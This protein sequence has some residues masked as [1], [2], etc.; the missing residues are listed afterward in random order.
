MK[1]LFIV[2]IILL[3]FSC[4]TTYEIVTRTKTKN[5]QKETYFYELMGKEQINM[6]FYDQKIEIGKKIKFNKDSTIKVLK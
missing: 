1:K 6:I 4:S 2:A 3:S 5:N